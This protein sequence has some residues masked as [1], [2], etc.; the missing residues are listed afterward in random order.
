MPTWMYAVIAV[1]PITAFWTAYRIFKILEK[2]N[3]SKQNE[4]E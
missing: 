2:R 3:N 4:D 1:L